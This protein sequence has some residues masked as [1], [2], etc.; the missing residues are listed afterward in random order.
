MTEASESPDAWGVPLADQI[1]IV[2]VTRGLSA[3]TRMEAA[4]GV[5]EP[6][7]NG[8][9]K[10]MLDA[11]NLAICTLVDLCI[12]KGTFTRGEYASTFVH[13]AELEL[14]DRAD[15]TGVTIKYVHFPVEEDS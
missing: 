2:E 12:E 15:K 6:M 11:C 14:L 10:L 4:N 8:S 1:R 3:M 13:R 7:D 9:L 5:G